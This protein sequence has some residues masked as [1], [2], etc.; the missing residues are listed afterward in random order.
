L[1][2]MEMTTSKLRSPRKLATIDCDFHQ[3]LKSFEDL[4]PYLPR[5]WWPRLEAPEAT[6]PI[7]LFKP[8]PLSRRDAS[9]GDGLPPGSDP[10]YAIKDALDRYNINKAVLTGSLLTV[11]AH[12]NPDYAAAMASAFNDYTLDHW[13]PTDD[14]WL[15]SILVATQ[16]PLLA[17]REIDRLG[18]HPKVVQVILPVASRE[19]FG[20]R[21]FYPIYEAAVRNNLVVAIHGGGEGD[22][23]NP[24][25][26]AVGTPTTN[27]ER[28]NILAIHHMSQLNS[29]VCEGVFETFPT[30]KVV[31]IEGGLAWVPHL[32][33][34][35]D[36]NFRG[37]RNE[38]PW[39]KK[40]PSEYI[41]EHCRFTTQPIEEPGNQELV[42]MLRMMRAEK[43]VMFA[44][45]YPHWDNDTPTF[46][47]N[48]L[49]EDLRR[50]IQFEN[51]AEL[52][53]LNSN[54]LVKEG[55]EV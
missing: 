25:I 33:W 23:I 37:M 10:Q 55:D 34:R 46:V 39:L 4:R 44:T 32:M 53:Q 5:V 13:I 22:G 43:T 50:R 12:N 9:P 52:Y 11:S 41:I 35:M 3:T 21:R 31:F 24:P 49:P 51:A 40:K 30:L 20:Q 28:H 6:L 48:K 19:P 45:D 47:L 8:I 36:K 2:S 16:D 18:S 1:D 42:Q 26:S 27:F 14:R 17:A 38:V 15:A 54:E 7:T 29:L